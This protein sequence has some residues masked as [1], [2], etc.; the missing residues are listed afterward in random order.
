MTSV[1]ISVVPN[2]RL[3]T[4]LEKTIKDA[5]VSPYIPTIFIIFGKSQFVVNFLKAVFHHLVINLVI[6]K[7]LLIITM[8]QT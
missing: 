2:V 7:Q 8:K 5:L 1:I 3:D 4:F 6:T